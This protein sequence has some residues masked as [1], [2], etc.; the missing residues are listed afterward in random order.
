MRNS[1]F[2]LVFVFLMSFNGIAQQQEKGKNQLPLLGDKAPAFKGESTMGTIN[3]PSD[4][5]DKW[6]ILFSHPA[7][8]TPVCSS[9]IVALASMQDDFAKLNTQIVVLSTDGL[10]SHK[11]WCRSLE[12]LN[13]DGYPPAKINFPLV[14]DVSLSISRKYGMIHLS[15]S[16]ARNIR[17]VF[18]I[19]PD[20]K[21]GAIFYY[22]SN[23]GR[24]L[25][26]IKRT[27]IALQTSQK[28]VVLT[29]VNWQKG[30]DV[31]LYAPTSAEELKKLEKKASSDP[32]GKIY[33]RAWYMWFKKLE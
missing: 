26:E 23:I 19:T 33:K 31:L 32:E 2:L 3:F 20:N 15:S 8:F 14:S 27:V 13:L 5:K 25:E 22:P 11:E 7:D 9:E 24:N 6:K 21:V 4:Y 28:N 17:A 12:S 18:I 30:Q 29:P 1:F 10:E 16:T